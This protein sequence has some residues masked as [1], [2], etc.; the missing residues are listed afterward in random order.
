VPENPHTAIVI[1]LYA[2][3]VALKTMPESDERE[4][5]NFIH[6]QLDQLSDAI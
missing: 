2:L 6:H 1:A 4:E 5:L 3:D